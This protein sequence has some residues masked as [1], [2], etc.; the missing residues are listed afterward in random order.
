MTTEDK[1]EV[2]VCRRPISSAWISIREP[3]GCVI[4]WRLTLAGMGLGVS[5]KKGKSNFYADALSRYKSLAETIVD[6]DRDV[7]SFRFEE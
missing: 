3:G 1:S 2:V 7:R 5:Y 6:E 4:R